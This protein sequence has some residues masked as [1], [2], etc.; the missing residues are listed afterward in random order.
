VNVFYEKGINVVYGGSKQGLM[1]V[2]ANEAM[3]LGLTVTGVIPYSLINKEVENHHISQ[4]FKVDTMAQRKE[5]MESLASGF[6]ALPGGYGTFD[7]IFE[8]LSKLQLGYHSKPC[9]FYNINGYYDKL[10]EFLN[11]SVEAGF[12]EKRFI[13]MVIISSDANELL[14]KII[15]F[16]PVKPKWE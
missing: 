9:A 2:I 16:K 10:I 1:G 5:K 7:E 15:E 8:V 6:I 4:L 3:R 13:D 14:D 12:I 11:Q